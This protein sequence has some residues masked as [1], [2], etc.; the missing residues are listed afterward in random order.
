MA[1]AGKHRGNQHMHGGEPKVA[2]YARRRGSWQ[3]HCT[4]GSALAVGMIS[5]D[6]SVSW[7]R[8]RGLQAVSDA[9]GKMSP[10]PERGIH[11][12]LGGVVVVGIHRRSRGGVV[13]ISGPKKAKEGRRTA[14]IPYLREK[15]EQAT[16]KTVPQ[17]EEAFVVEER[18]STLNSAALRPL[19]TRRRDWLSDPP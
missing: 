19:A 11:A 7:R 2:R 18:G 3:G 16:L 9:I 13:R 12:C 17:P 6:V 1:T 4:A 8:G 15:G 14:Q 5:R 10:E